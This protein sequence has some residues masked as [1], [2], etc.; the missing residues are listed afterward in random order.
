[1]PQLDW[2]WILEL[3]LR[4]V[5]PLMIRGNMIAPPVVIWWLICCKWI[6]ATAVPFFNIDTD[7]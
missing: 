2:E 1:M 4:V 7:S 5:K 3:L 6:N